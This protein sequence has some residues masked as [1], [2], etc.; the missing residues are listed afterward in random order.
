L[1]D[2]L[3][4]LSLSSSA[5]VRTTALPVR[6]C[7]KRQYT[8]GMIRDFAQTARR[9]AKSF[10][11]G[12][13]FY[14]SETEC[15]RLQLGEINARFVVNPAL[16][17]PT[18]VF[19]SFGIGT[20]IS[21]DLECIKRFSLQIH[22]F[23]PTPR[24]LAWLGRQQ[25]PSGFLVHP[26][27]VADFDGT[28]TLHPPADPTHV[29]YSSIDNGGEGVECPVYK[30]TTIMKT[31]GHDKLD[32]LKIDIEGAEYGV[33][34]EIVSQ[35]IPI[36][37]IC[38]EFHHRWRHIGGRKTDDAVDSL[39]SVGYQIFHVAPTGEEFSFIRT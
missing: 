14:R 33:I 1:S 18:S 37:Q 5:A 30:L 8:G 16:L 15:P 22:A 2:K 7:K 25:L 12:P 34:R 32:L 13:R 4:H 29:S 39:R 6:Q 3:F 23:D 38:V 24:S 19:Y 27:G 9:F 11:G 21:F 20:D 28:I 10:S 36:T 35:R 17:G 31:L 26:Y